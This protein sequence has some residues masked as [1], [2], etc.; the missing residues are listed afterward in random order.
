MSMAE[1]TKPQPPDDPSSAP[2]SGT[3]RTDTSGNKPSD[4]K[5][6]PNANQRGIN[7]SSKDDPDTA[8]EER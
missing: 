3:V 4:P 5:T 2:E 7:P 6:G 8:P 1:P